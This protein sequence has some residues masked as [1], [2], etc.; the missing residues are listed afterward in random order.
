M[1]L[2]AR[3]RRARQCAHRWRVA[4]RRDNERVGRRLPPRRPPLEHLVLLETRSGLSAAPEA[5]SMRLLWRDRPIRA[6]QVAAPEPVLD[7]PVANE[8]GIRSR[9]QYDAVP[10]WRRVPPCWC[11]KWPTPRSTPGAGCVSQRGSCAG[12][13]TEWRTTAA[14]ISSNGSDRGR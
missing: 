10:A 5:T 14:W 2:P 12:G 4:Q 7:A 9:W 11:A 13:P 1:W 8:H 3:G 6:D